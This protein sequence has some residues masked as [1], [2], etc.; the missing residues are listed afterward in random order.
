MLKFNKIIWRIIKKL[1]N[2]AKYDKQRA[3]LLSKYFK[4]IKIGKNVL[5]GKNFNFSTDVQI[6]IGDNTEI[7]SSCNIYN[8][9]KSFEASQ[10]KLTIGKNC[11][12]MANAIFDCSAPIFIGDDCHLGRNVKIFTHNHI[13]NNPKR[14]MNDS[15]I[16]LGG[17]TIGTNSVVY[18]DVC[19][20]YK[21]EIPEG[22]I[23]G[24]KSLVTKI[25][26]NKN[27]ILAGIPAK[28]IKNRYQ[29]ENF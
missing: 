27:M 12:V 18:D 6:E 21:S 16:S 20:L 28:E 3:K 22:C 9:L 11:N 2:K 17:V 23:I 13:L 29:D 25:F 10:R 26:I 14:K 24:V 19:I 1:P 7:K 8:D 4:N 5:I 15:D